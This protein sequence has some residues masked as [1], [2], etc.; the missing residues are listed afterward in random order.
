MLFF[1]LLEVL[2]ERFR[3]KLGKLLVRFRVLLVVRVFFCGRSCVCL[4]Y[5]LFMFFWKVFFM[6][7]L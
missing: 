5:G 2:C 1:R 4:L 3:V 7:S 6:F